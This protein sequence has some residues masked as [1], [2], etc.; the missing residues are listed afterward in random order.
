MPR[1]MSLWDRGGFLG[2]TTLAAD[3]NLVIQLAMGVALLAGMMLARRK[4]YRAHGIC[5]GS[6]MALNLVM[7]ALIMLP[8]FQDNVV[9]E[10]PGRLLRLHYLVPTIHAALGGIAQLMGIYIVLRAGTNWLPQALCFQNYKL[11]MRTEL[12]LWWAVII[13]GVVTYVVWS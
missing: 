9:P 7:L 13:I 8:S 1:F 5:Q 6:V 4:R 2:G 3:I 11:W 10:L 12:V